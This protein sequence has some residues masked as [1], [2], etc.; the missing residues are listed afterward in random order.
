MQVT[1]YLLSQ[2]YRYTLSVF[3]AESGTHNLPQL[4]HADLLRLVGVA[5]GSHVHTLLVSRSE[6]GSGCLAAGILEALAHVE[7]SVAPTITAGCQT[8][9]QPAA[10]TALLSRLAAIEEEYQE[11]SKQVEVVAAQSVE[12]RVAACQQEC[13]RRY[14]AQL[15]AE[16]SKLKEED[17][18]IGRAHV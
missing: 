14:A 13:E 8:D 2:Q 1:E 15:Q 6:A 3:L 18:Q 10:S 17:L 7:G 16:L 5:H 4:S 11:R 9:E 12:A